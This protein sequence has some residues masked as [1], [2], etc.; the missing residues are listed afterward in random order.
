MK[1]LHLIFLRGELIGNLDLITGIKLLE[2]QG[3]QD[4]KTESAI[5][6]TTAKQSS[7]RRAPKTT[8]IVR[9]RV[10]RQLTQTETKSEQVNLGGKC[11][12]SKYQS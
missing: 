8:P 2:T 5:P 10:P 3:K 11:H 12:F 6:S 7:Y 4:K 1:S 9:R